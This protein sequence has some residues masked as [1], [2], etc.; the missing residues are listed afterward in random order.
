[1]PS[2]PPPRSRP[3]KQARL[4]RRD[5]QVCFNHEEIARQASCADCGES[6]CGECLVSFADAVVCGPCKNYRVKNLQ[7]SLPPS[8]LSILSLLVAFLSAPV[9]LLLLPARQGGFPWWVFL[10]VLPQGLAVALALLALREADKDPQSAGRSL[11]LTGLVSAGVTTAL[12]L[13]LAMY[14]PHRWT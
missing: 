14:A 3:R 9:I 13:L 4:G 6:F 7:R 5:P 2:K 1:M 8:N 10:A 12:I 11:A